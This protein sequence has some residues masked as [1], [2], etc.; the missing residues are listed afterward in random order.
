MNVGNSWLRECCCSTRWHKVCCIALPRI[1]LLLLTSVNRGRAGGVESAVRTAHRKRFGEWCECS[2]RL[3][4]RDSVTTTG[5]AGAGSLRCVRVPLCACAAVPHGCVPYGVTPWRAGRERGVA[6][7]RPRGR[8]GQ[9]AGDV[10][11]WVAGGHCKCVQGWGGHLRAQNEEGSPSVRRNPARAEAYY[12]RVLSMSASRAHVV[13]VCVCACAGAMRGRRVTRSTTRPR[14]QL[15]GA[16][17][18]A[19]RGCP[20]RRRAA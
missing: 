16:R 3:R 20:A 2:Q 12:R 17:A 4:R 19:C 6:A 14:P 9:R 13:P 1:P 8:C 5:T 18:D 10:Q 11:S 15:H 7:V